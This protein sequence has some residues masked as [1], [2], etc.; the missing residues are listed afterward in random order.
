MPRNC[1]LLLNKTVSQIF[2]FPSLVLHLRTNHRNSM[3]RR[4]YYVVFVLI[5]ALSSQRW[6]FLSF[7]VDVFYLRS[8]D[9]SPGLGLPPTFSLI[10]LYHR[11]QTAIG[12]KKACSHSLVFTRETLIITE[13]RAQGRP[14]CSISE[15]Q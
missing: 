8:F 7:Y 6:D 14:I 13:R 5:A 9:L 1:I 15:Q 12:Q 11:S 10:L 4:L 2:Y 3:V